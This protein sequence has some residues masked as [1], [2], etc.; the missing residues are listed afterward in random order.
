MSRPALKQQY[1]EKVLEELKQECGYKNVHEVPFLEKVV[2]NS[3]ISANEDKSRLEDVFSL[4]Q[5]ITGQKPVYTLSRK[6]ISNFKLREGA[7][8]GVKV[9]LRGDQMYHFLYKLI[10][11]TLPLIRDFR[12]V[13]KKMDGKGNYTFGIQDHTIFPEASSSDSGKKSIGMDITI[14]TSADSDDEG[15]S[16]LFKLGMPFRGMVQQQG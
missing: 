2:I 6:S 3:G 15:R 16:L 11:I 8:I 13:S 10:N 14:V 1:L 12:G 7:K 4:I 9:T 5:T